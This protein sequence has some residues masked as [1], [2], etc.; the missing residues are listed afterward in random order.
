MPNIPF[1]L[2]LICLGYFFTSIS[3]SPA[4]DD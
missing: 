3:F 2:F 4:L 1:D